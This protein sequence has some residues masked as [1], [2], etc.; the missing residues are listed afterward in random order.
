VLP[1]VPVTVMLEVE[2]GTANPV[3]LPHAVSPAA[4]ARP[5]ASRM[6]RLRR[7]IRRRCGHSRRTQPI[8]T[9]AGI[10]PN[11]P[12]GSSPDLALSAR[13]VMVIVLVAACVVP[14]VTLAGERLTE[15]PAGSPLAASVTGAANGFPETVE[16]SCMV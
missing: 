1:L 4:Q 13:T 5:A 11:G 15:A 10:A 3:P 8:E 14:G 16:R 2:P 12:L 7:R 6:S 9:V